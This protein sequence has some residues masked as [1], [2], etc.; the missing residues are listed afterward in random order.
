VHRPSAPV[1]A[2]VLE[3]SSAEPGCLWASVHN[4]SASELSLPH[5]PVVGLRAVARDRRWRSACR[6]DP[7]PAPQ[8]LSAGQTRSWNI[9][10]AEALRGEGGPP[11][12]GEYELWVVFRLASDGPVTISEAVLC[13][14]A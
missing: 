7:T 5:A 2:P 8:T 1:D 10:W 12:P 13:R 11:P 4:P 6:F 3:V 9:G 14:Q